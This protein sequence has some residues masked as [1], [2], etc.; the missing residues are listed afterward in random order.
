MRNLKVEVIMEPDS[1]VYSTEDNHGLKHGDWAMF[2]DNKD[3]FLKKQFSH[4]GNG[5]FVVSIGTEGL[6]FSTST[7]Y[8]YYAR[9]IPNITYK[10]FT[11][12]TFERH[13]N[14]WIKWK[15]DGIGD[16]DDT[17]RCYA[18]SYSRTA[19]WVGIATTGLLWKEALEKLEFEDGTPF[20]E[21][22][23]Q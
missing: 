19:V 5:N 15:N 10:P 1:T 17:Y 7:A 18:A 9:K 21:E 4:V 23:V 8:Y 13:R 2:S 6:Y 22:D 14:R 11:P 20:G 16:L 3:T 12:E